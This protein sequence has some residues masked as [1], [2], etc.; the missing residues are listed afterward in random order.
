MPSWTDTHTLIFNT[1]TYKRIQFSKSKYNI[2]ANKKKLAFIETRQSN[3][4]C[5]VTLTTKSMLECHPWGLWQYRETGEHWPQAGWQKC[6]ITFGTSDI[7]SVL[8]AAALIHVIHP[9]YVSDWQKL[10]RARDLEIGATKAHGTCLHH[11]L[12]F[13]DRKC[14]PIGAK[15]NCA[16]V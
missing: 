16:P 3:E 2:T 10:Q 11:T 1:V 15:P 6:I 4:I 14:H 8:L 7:L 13:Q 12:C 9:L 5:S